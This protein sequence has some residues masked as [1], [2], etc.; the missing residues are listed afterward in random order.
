V[1]NATLLSNKYAIYSV[2]TNGALQ[3]VVEINNQ[4]GEQFKNICGELNDVGEV[5]EENNDEWLGDN[6]ESSDS[7]S[8][9]STPSNER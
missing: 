7:R 1:I 8:T 3:T 5:D 4:I 6:M 9:S 2:L